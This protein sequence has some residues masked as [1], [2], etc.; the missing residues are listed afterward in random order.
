MAC[1]GCRVLLPSQYSLLETACRPLPRPLLQA[2]ELA[3]AA[4]A[5]AKRGANGCAAREQRGAAGPGG[6]QQDPDSEVG[7]SGAVSALVGWHAVRTPEATQ[8]KQQ[9]SN[10]PRRSTFHTLGSAACPPPRRLP[11]LTRSHTALQGERLRAAIRAKMR[12][13]APQQERVR[14]AVLEERRLATEVTDSTLLD[15][16]RLRRPLPDGI[17]PPRSRTGVPP[18]EPP[19]Q[20]AALLQHQQAARA[21]TAA[22]AARAEREALQRRH[23]QRQQQPQQAQAAADGSAALPGQAADS[24]GQLPAPMHFNPFMRGGGGPPLEEQQQQQQQQQASPAM[25]AAAGTPPPQRSPGLSGGGRAGGSADG[26][27]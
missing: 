12:R 11:T 20:P 19:L 1:S 8:R 22:K 14:Q 21:A 9:G 5:F 17:G 6:A 3:E 2:A 16:R 13:L 24:S 10:R 27:A 7:W 23:L 18:F 4:A 25:T 26:A 15:W